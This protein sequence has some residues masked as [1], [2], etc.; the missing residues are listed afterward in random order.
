[1]DEDLSIGNASALDDLTSFNQLAGL[2]KVDIEPG[3][4]S[5]TFTWAKRGV[6]LTLDG[7]REDGRGIAAEVSGASLKQDAGRPSTLCRLD[8]FS[9]TQRNTVATY[10][11]ASLPIRPKGKWHELLDDACFMAIRHVRQEEPIIRLVSQSTITPPQFRLTPLV[12]ERLPTVMFTGPGVAKSY[13]ALFLSML[14]QSGS[15]LGILS[16]QQGEALEHPHFESDEDDFRYRAELIRRGHPALKDAE[17]P[18]YLRC[19]RPLVDSITSIQRHVERTGCKFVVVDS[20][21]PA[22]GQDLDRAETAL[23]FYAALR[24]LKKAAFVIAHQPEEQRHDW[25]LFK[26]PQGPLQCNGQDHPGNYPAPTAPAAKQTPSQARSPG[27][28]ISRASWT[29][30]A[31]P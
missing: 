13:V 16:G 1:M 23:Q 3:P 29:R 30:S 7:I 10:L 6:R 17:E 19:H 20:V 27:R 25:I 31:S 21:G 14:V 15:D 2:Q 26:D 24:S 5:L 8:L 12:Y 4:S 11:Q 22:C 18:S 28:P 9:P